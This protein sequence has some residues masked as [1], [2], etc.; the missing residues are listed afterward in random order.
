MRRFAAA[1]LVATAAFAGCGRTS[2]LTF[3][4][5]SGGSEAGLPT[6]GTVATGGTF[7]SGGS[8]ATGGSGGSE[9]G[10]GGFGGSGGRDAA[11][12]FAGT[13]GSG[14]VRD[15]G[16]D[17]WDPVHSPWAQC[18]N[19]C[20]WADNYTGYLVMRALMDTCACENL[21]A[22]YCVTDAGSGCVI[23]DSN[24]PMQPFLDCAFCEDATAM[25]GVCGNSVTF[26]LSAKGFYHC[27]ERCGPP[28]ADAPLPQ[29]SLDCPTGTPACWSRSHDGAAPDAGACCPARPPAE[30]APCDNDDGLTDCIYGTTACQCGYKQ[31]CAWGCS[32]YD[33]SPAPL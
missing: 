17:G 29:G 23:D 22:R 26:Q 8:A 13:A 10:T 30:G 14:G 15:A 24:V 20:Y 16:P 7:E 19:H 28:P 21:C 11:A 5:S 12:G 4:A 25:M 2:L 31:T 33:P 9:A 6:G 3:G 27:L 32:G 1:L 18:V